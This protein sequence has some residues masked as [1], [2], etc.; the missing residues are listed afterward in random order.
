[1][2]PAD[3]AAEVRRIIEDAEEVLPRLQ[4][5]S[6]AEF[7]RL[8]LPPRELVLDPWLPQ[9]GLAMVHSPRG[10][11]KT[12]FG[13]S[14]AY[15]VATGTAFLGFD[16]PKPRPVLFLDG[17]MPAAIMQRRLAAIVAG[18]EQQPSDPTF[19]RL[20]SADITE[21]GL[22]DLGT[23]NGQ[24]EFN[25]AIGYAELIAVDNISTLVRNGKE[26]EGESW[27]LVQEWALEHRRA[28]RSWS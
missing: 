28:G 11:G 9:K 13:L 12:H 26:N 22:P 7:L 25:E 21:G 3:G 5:L 17:E 1:M 20:L 18:V 14:V 2:S 15:A 4:P 19:F 10:V 6:V 27:L 23:A 8:E 16:A 24:A